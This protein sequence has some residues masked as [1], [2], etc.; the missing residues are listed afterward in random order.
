MEILTYVERATV[1]WNPDGTIKGSEAHSHTG[2]FE[3][4][5]TGEG[6]V[7]VFVVAKHEVRPVLAGDFDGL[8]AD[9]DQFLANAGRELTDKRENRRQHLADARAEI[10]ALT[11]A[12]AEQAASIEKQA[13][14]LA[15]M[16]AELI[17]ARAKQLESEKSVYRLVNGLADEFTQ[18]G[19]SE[20]VS[21]LSRL[22]DDLRIVL[23][24]SPTVAQ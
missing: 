12:S 1:V 15:G 8:I 21:G 7:R 3:D 18:N 2:W 4:R 14:L 19:N 11:V 24:P 5:D 20:A 23:Q 22:L 17:A 6:S 9:G 10:A 13:K 16:N